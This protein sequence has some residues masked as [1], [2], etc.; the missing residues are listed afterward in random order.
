LINN[1]PDKGARIRTQIDGLRLELRPLYKS[2]KELGEIPSLK[3]VK[4]ET[5][6][7][8]E[9]LAPFELLP[10]KKNYQRPG[11]IFIRLCHCEMHFKL[12]N[13]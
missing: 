1:L 13:F 6:V 5:N 3:E 7:P 9:Q 8:A 4:K 11:G 10:V 2:L 12:C